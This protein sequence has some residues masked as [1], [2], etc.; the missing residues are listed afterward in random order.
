MTNAI[1]FTRLEK[2]RH[3]RV[4][5]GISLERPVHYGDSQ[6]VFLRSPEAKNAHSLSKDWAKGQKVRHEKHRCAQLLTL[7][8]RTSFS[9]SA[10]LVADLVTVSAISCLP[11]SRKLHRGHIL[12]TVR[13]PHDHMLIN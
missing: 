1:K 9:R 12:T 4:N 5:L 6:V 8:R 7:P 3:I 13:P 10:T 11:D 2:K